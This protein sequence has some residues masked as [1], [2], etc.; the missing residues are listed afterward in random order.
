MR[1]S[2]LGVGFGG[3]TWNSSESSPVEIVTGVRGW[4]IS[5]NVY[6]NDDSLFP[7]WVGLNQM[8]KYPLSRNLLSWLNSRVVDDADQKQ[9]IWNFKLTTIFT[10]VISI[11]IYPYGFQSIY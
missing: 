7:I 1:T 10:T 11:M 8:T 3:Q 4:E 2:Q 6:F 5:I 9:E